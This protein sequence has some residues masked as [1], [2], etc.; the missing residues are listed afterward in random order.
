MGVNRYDILMGTFIEDW[1]PVFRKFCQINSACAPSE[2]GDKGKFKVLLKFDEFTKTWNVVACNLTI[3]IKTS[4][5]RTLISKSDFAQLNVSMSDFPSGARR[6]F[7]RT[8]R[9]SRLRTL[10]AGL[11]LGLTMPLP[12]LAQGNHFDLNVPHPFISPDARGNT[13]L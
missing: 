3:S 13:V 8:R 1:T 12:V 9:A 5:R 4:R 6:L 10:R 2:K 11:C 7:V